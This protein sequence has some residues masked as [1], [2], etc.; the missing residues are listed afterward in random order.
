[1]LHSHGPLLILAGAGSGKTTVLVARTGRLIE[2]GIVPASGI[3]VLTFTNKAARELKHRVSVKLGAKGADLWTGTFHSFGLRLLR[4]YHQAAG[5]PT[6]FGVIDSSDS[7]GILRELMQNMTVAGKD[8]F[9]LEKLLNLV[10]EFRARGRFSGATDEYH[11]LAEALAPK[12]QKKMQMLGVV[13]FEELLLKPLELLKKNP[14]IKEKLQE[15]FPYL[16]VD[17]FQD[18]NSVQMK[19]IEQLLGPKQN[20]A[21][22]GDDD[23]SIYGWRGAEISNIL[24]FPKRYASCEVIRLERNYRSTS[25]ILDFANHVIG[26][27]DK[28]HGKVLKPES[29]RGTGEVP[30]LFVFSNEEEEAETVVREIKWLRDQGRPLREA[31][32]LYRSNS[33]SGLI[34]ALLRQEQIAFSVSGGTAFFDRKE[35]KDALAYLRLSLGQSDLHFR[36]ILNVPARGI[37]DTSIEKIVEHM[38]LKKMGFQKA[39][40]DWKGAD[41]QEK[42][43]A[44]ID[45]LLEFLKTMPTKLMHDL[46]LM[47]GAKFVQ[48]MTEIGYR[49]YIWLSSKDPK[50]GEKRWRGVEILG[51][52]LDRFVEKGGRDV[53]TLREFVD[54]M[55][56]RDDPNEEG[57]KNEVSLM[58]LHASKGLEFP[59]VFLMGIEEDLLPHRTLGSDVSE[60]RRLFYVGITRAQEKLFLTRCRTRKR[61]GQARPV[62]P[63]RFVLGLP[64]GLIKTFEEGVRPVSGVQRDDMVANFL[65]KL[66]PPAKPKAGKQP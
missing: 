10:H 65:A 36:R 1:M 52:I 37:G 48:L 21:V 45:S 22:V 54:A 58:T 61:Y 53:K 29:S 34:E 31:A 18:T 2:D 50:I 60:E 5:L 55:E 44:S 35:V 49:D 17:E 59:V 51:R 41:V 11:E 3:C 27:N 7:T 66:Q 8:K 23:Q 33:Q 26:Q 24:D 30:E 47:P 12:Y 63:S 15:K 6:T 42:A 4:Q 57:A 20:I 64:E 13:D 25:R 40:A 38:A 62:S 43:G 46:S 16:M 32:V 28:R 14:D 39:A 9:D 56:L 19:L